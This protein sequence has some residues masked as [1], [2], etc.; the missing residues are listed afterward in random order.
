[1]ASVLEIDE[2]LYRKYNVFS[3]CP[4]DQR[5]VPAKAHAANVV[6]EE[7]EKKD[8]EFNEK[9]RLDGSG[10]VKEIKKKHKTTLEYFI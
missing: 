7:E 9:S 6:G 4:S 10:K 8:F 5:Q 1:M 3:A 2:N